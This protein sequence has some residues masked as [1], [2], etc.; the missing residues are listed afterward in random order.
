MDMMWYLWC[1]SNSP[2]FGKKR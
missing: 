2:L 1:G